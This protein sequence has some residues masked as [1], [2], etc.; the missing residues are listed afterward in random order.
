MT[1]LKVYGITKR[2]TERHIVAA[3]SLAEAA[4]KLNVSQLQFA[5]SG[6]ETRNEEEVKQ[7]MAMPGSVFSRPAQAGTTVQWCLVEDFI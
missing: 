1:E 5:Q 4:E 7:A 6:S 3:P 2:G